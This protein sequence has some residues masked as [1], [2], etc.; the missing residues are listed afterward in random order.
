MS[1]LPPIEE[2]ERRFVRPKPGRAL[3]VGSRVFGEKIDRRTLYAEAVGVDMEAGAGVDVVMDL[4]DGDIASLGLFDH[5]DCLS[6]LEHSRRPWLLA[7]NIERLM[8]PGATIYLSVPFVW[9]LH[10][11]PGDFFRYTDQGVRALFQNIQWAHLSYASEKL[12]TDHYLKASPMH[13][14]PYLPRCEVFGWGLRT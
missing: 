10:E 13:S 1:A 8:A 4:E 9:R 6:V 3:V 12:R 14:Y 11:Y 2:F 5:V 7:A